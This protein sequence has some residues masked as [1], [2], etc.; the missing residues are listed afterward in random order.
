[1]TFDAAD[2]E[3]VL[4]DPSDGV[5]WTWDGRH[6]WALRHPLSVPTEN[7]GKI[8][9]P[10]PAMAWDPSTSSVL[11]IV[12]DPPGRP[13]V[14]I[15]SQVAPA[16]WSWSAGQWTELGV[17]TPDYVEGAMGSFPPSRQVILFSGCCDYSQPLPL[18]CGL[19]SQRP[20]NAMWAWNGVEWTELHP[21]HMPP[22]RLG[23]SMAYDPSL[24]KLLL[25]GGVGGSGTTFM[26]DLWEWDGV[27]WTQAVSAQV[28]PNLVAS[29]ALSPGGLVAV[30]ASPGFAQTWSWD[31]STWQRLEASTP[32]CLICSLAY[33]PLRHL[34][35]LVDN[36]DYSSHVAN[37]VWTWDGRIW[38]RR[39]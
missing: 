1:M 33:D 36:T 39:A 24:G 17:Q 34:T 19:G 4:M 5:T 22:A 3:L 32:D 21:A 9:G 23:G 20:V 31:G 30:A 38:T 15:P 8:G 16:T 2:G 25:F 14:A 37:Q 29:A 28:D 12:G 11:A 26:S 13:G 6:A 35:V 10:S 18:C 27:D 7:S